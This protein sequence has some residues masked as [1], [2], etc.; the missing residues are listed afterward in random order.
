MLKYKIWNQIQWHPKSKQVNQNFKAR[1]AGGI[2]FKPCVKECC[3]RSQHKKE[4]LV[5]R[6]RSVFAAGKHNNMLPNGAHFFK[7]LKNFFKSAL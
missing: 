1:E 5:L 7:F 2:H 4:A 6:T 3:V